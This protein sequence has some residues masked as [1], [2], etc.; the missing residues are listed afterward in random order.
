LEQGAAI[1]GNSPR[2]IEKHYS[3]W[4]Q[5]RQ[6]SINAAVEATWA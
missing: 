6:D 2:I 5:A 3:H 4:I 1:L